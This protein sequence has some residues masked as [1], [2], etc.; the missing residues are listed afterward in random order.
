MLTFCG[1][2]RKM[3]ASVGVI[4]RDGNV[5]KALKALKKKLEK[6][7]LWGYDP[8]NRYYKEGTKRKRGKKNPDRL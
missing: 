8:K 4:V 1:W 3:K 5:D 6:E 2:R 7:G